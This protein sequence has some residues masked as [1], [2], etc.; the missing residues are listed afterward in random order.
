MKGYVLQFMDG[1]IVWRRGFWERQEDAQR[2]S[3]KALGMTSVVEIEYFLEG[4]RRP[5]E[6]LYSRVQNAYNFGF[7]SGLEIG[8]KTQ[9]VNDCGR[10]YA[11]GYAKGWMESRAYSAKERTEV[12]AAN[13]SQYKRINELEA[14]LKDA[15]DNV[16]TLEKQL[17]LAMDAIIVYNLPPY[18]PEIDK[19]TTSLKKANAKIDYLQDELEMVRRD[20]QN[21]HQNGFREGYNVGVR[22]GRNQVDGERRGSW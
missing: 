15:N 10:Q 16:N 5:Q 11:D 14:S 22:S 12:T 9:S 4:D 17:E 7:D 2:E 20:G 21:A 13:E 6:E 8:R 19:L 1:R 18:Q 3:R